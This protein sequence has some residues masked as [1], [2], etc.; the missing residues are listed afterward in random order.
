MEGPRQLSVLPHHL[1]SVVD[2]LMR[3]GRWER[4]G[5][6]TWRRAVESG[7]GV[8][9]EVEAGMMV[10]FRVLEWGEGGPGGE[11][12]GWWVRWFHG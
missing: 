4:A 5:W 2:L 10:E 7:G 12:C 11:S 9:V 3:T 1:Q 8:G 6:E